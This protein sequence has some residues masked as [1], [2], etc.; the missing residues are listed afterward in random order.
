[1]TDDKILVPVWLTKEQ[2]SSVND[3]CVCGL[4][5]CAPCRAYDEAEAAFHEAVRAALARKGEAWEGW[6]LRDTPNTGNPMYPRV[7]HENPPTGPLVPHTHGGSG[8][9]DMPIEVR[10]LVVRMDEP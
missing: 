3:L 6:T 9:A 10:V 4:P 8:P 7:V 2:A 5:S 1:M